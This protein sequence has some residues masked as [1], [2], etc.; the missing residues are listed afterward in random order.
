MPASRRRRGNSRRQGRPGQKRLA[1]QSQKNLKAWQLF[2]QIRQQSNKSPFSQQG[3]PALTYSFRVGSMNI[4]HT[5]IL[6]RQH[7]CQ[8]LVSPRLRG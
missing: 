5:L 2:L 7:A 1:I 8:R 6:L 3:L 4:A